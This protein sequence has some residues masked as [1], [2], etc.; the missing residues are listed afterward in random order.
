MSEIIKFKEKPLW[1]H[2]EQ[3]ILQPAETTTLTLPSTIKTAAKSFCFTQ[4]V[5]KN[6]ASEYQYN[7]KSFIKC[8][9]EYKNEKLKNEN[10]SILFNRDTEETDGVF[11]N[12]SVLLLQGN[13]VST[14]TLTITN[15]HTTEPLTLNNLVIYESDDIQVTTIAKVLKEETIRADM[16]HATTIIA[17]DI[18]VQEL[19]TAIKDRDANS[20]SPG[21]EVHWKRIS[22]S[23]T[24]YGIDIL[25][26]E[27]EQLTRSVVIA[28]REYTYSYWW[29]SISGEDAYKYLTTR[30]PHEFYPEMPDSERE[31][32]KYL[33]LKPESSSIKKS[34]SFALDEA[35]NYIPSDIYG[36]GD[37]NGC[38]Q[39]FIYK[40]TNGFYVMYTQR[41]GNK[42]GL[43]MDDTGVYL[44]GV[45]NRLAE[46]V[47]W[48]KDGFILK[49]T[50]EEARFFE[51]IFNESSKL[52]GILQDEQYLMSFYDETDKS[53]HD[54][55]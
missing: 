48:R 29:T 9:I 34:V 8:K 54:G 16:I 39:G 44:Q 46:Y 35:N 42:V 27:K 43:V 41:S 26:S 50:A 40:N 6:G 14:V 45:V 18:L 13:D 24:L 12:S 4:E 28:G 32:Y 19:E 55:L 52:T 53:I 49:K 36:A 47:K 17:D 25:G 23:E 33:V 51:Y 22:G 15:N 31:K 30:D 2:T 38:S 11:T 37:G 21:D 1:E 3:I 7:V 5:V 20:A 10:F